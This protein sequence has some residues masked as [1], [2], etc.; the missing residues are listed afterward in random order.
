MY[1]E[2]CSVS[3]PLRSVLTKNLA[4]PTLLPDMCFNPSKELT[5]VLTLLHRQFAKRPTVCF[6]PSKELTA[7]LTRVT[8]F[9]QQ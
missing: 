2:V 3:I 9:L 7:V 1:F 6:N 8:W 4:K 5:A